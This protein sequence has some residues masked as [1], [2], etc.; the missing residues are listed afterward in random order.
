MFVG[1]STISAATRVTIAPGVVVKFA[2]QSPTELGELIVH[3][4]LQA[5][6]TATA[7]VIFTSVHDDSAGGRI[8]RGEVAVRRPGTG[9]E[10]RLRAALR[11]RWTTPTCATRGEDSL[12]SVLW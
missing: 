10:S 1:A 4:S 11:S 6:G 2:P 9:T 3:G 5:N 12:A 8:T 7:P